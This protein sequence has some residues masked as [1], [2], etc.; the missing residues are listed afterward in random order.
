[1]GRIQASRLVDCKFMTLLSHSAIG[2]ARAWRGAGQK[3]REAGCATARN[4]SHKGAASA[5]D[6][7]R[8]N[9]SAV[10][11][12]HENRPKYWRAAL[13][14]LEFELTGFQ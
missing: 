14:R 2:N 7:S 6:L 12:A 11:F 9:A 5:M 10:N 13:E 3:S 4:S 8:P 1:M